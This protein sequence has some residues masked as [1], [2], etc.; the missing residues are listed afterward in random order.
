MGLSCISN[1][2]FQIYPYYTIIY[3][4]DLIDILK[5]GF[6]LKDKKDFIDD[7]ELNRQKGKTNF[8]IINAIKRSLWGLIGVVIGS[9]FIYNSPNVYS[10]RDYF[11]VYLV[12]FSVVFIAAA[13]RFLHLWGKNEGIYKK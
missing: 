4:K 9:I 5:G 11:Y 6:R 10:F 3:I 13:L 1:K 2:Y 8:V 7:W 12:V